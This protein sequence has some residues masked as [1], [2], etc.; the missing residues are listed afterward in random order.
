MHRHRQRGFT[1]IELLVVIAIMAILVALLLPA[2]QQARD[3]ARR[4]SCKN[5]IKQ[6]GFALHSYYNAFETFPPGVSNPRGPIEQIPSGYHHSWITSL[7]PYLD[8]ALLADKLDHTS[9]IY[10]ASNDTARAYQIQT[11]LCPTDPASSIAVNDLNNVAL[12][13][14]AGV[15]HHLANPIDTNN[16]GVLFLNSRV[17]YKDIPDGSSFTLLSGEVKR[18]P[19]DLGWASGTRAT[20]RN[21]GTNINQTPGG[22]R[23]YNDLLSSVGQPSMEVPVNALDGDENLNGDTT[24]WYDAAMSDQSSM[25]GSSMGGGIAENEDADAIENETQQIRRPP[26]APLPINFAYQ[27]GGFGSFH[28][29]GVQFLLCDGSVRFL[30][31]NLD[32]LVYQSLADRADGGDIV[33]F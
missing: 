16:H 22:S 24:Y 28:V 19:L 11:L 4:T 13:S 30:S 5:N 27:P 25:G 20:L 26:N 9:S 15:H 31:E 33:D 12:S 10:A 17:R 2:V 23:Y 7:L 18:S 3:A 1:L 32:P 29:G 6:I 8:Q 21:T 14:Y